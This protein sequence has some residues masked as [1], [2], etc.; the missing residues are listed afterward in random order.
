MRLVRGDC[1]Q[2]RAGAVAFSAEQNA[3]PRKK[4]FDSPKV[5][6]SFLG[7]NSDEFHFYVHFVLR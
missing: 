7:R 1:L 4:T 6:M 5:K 2:G 3:Q